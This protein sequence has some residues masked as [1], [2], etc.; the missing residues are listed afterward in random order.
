LVDKIDE[1][2]NPHTTF[3]SIQ[4]LNDVWCMILC[5]FYGRIPKAREN[6]ENERNEEEELKLKNVKPPTPCSPWSVLPNDAPLTTCQCFV[7]AF[8]KKYE[9]KKDTSCQENKALRHVN[10]G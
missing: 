7:A 6:G 2:L 9:D 4:A 10:P 8:P 5:V 3:T 1:D